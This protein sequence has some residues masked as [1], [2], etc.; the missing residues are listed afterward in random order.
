MNKFMKTSLLASATALAF[1]AG[2][3]IV[4]EDSFDAAGYT[5]GTGLKNLK[6]GASTGFAAGTAW[7]DSSSS[8]VFY[9]ND[10]LSLPDDFKASSSGNAIGVGKFS[11]TATGSREI[12]RPINADVIGL[13]GTYYLRFACSI[14]ES[15]E[16]YLNFKGF[17]LLGL[18]PDEHKKSDAISYPAS[19]GLQFGF[20]KTSA[21]D[22]KTALVVLKEGGSNAN[23]DPLK[24]VDPVVPGKTYIVVAKIVLDGEGG[25]EV[26]AMAG[27]TDDLSFRTKSLPETPFAVSVNAS[28]PLRYLVLSGTF[29][30]GYSDGRWASF[31]ELAI[32]E[33]LADVFGF[34]ALTIP[35]LG[36]ATSSNVGQE[37]FSASGELAQ[38]GDSSPEVFF[39]ISADGG[40]TFTSTSLGVFNAAGPISHQ[41]TGLSAGT[42]Y[43]WRFRAVGASGSDANEWQSVT[44][45][46]APALGAPSAEVAGSSAT[47]SV[48]LVTPG[49]SGTVDST[50]EL[51]F[52]ADGQPLA[53]EATLGTASFPT[54]FSATV[55]NLTLGETYCYAFRATVPYNS[56]SIET[57]SATNSFSISA[58]VVWTG[59]AGT[60]WGEAGNWNPQIAPVASVS[61][62]FRTVGGAVTSTANGEAAAIHV[63]TAGS[64][65][66]F[67][68]G[69]NSLTAGSFKVGSETSQS[70]AA[71]GPGGYDF[72][73]VSIG[74]GSDVGG[75][76]DGSAENHLEVGA[77]A[78]LR[79]D[80]MTVGF[81]LELASASNTV[82]FAAGSQSTIDGAL[83]IRAA[84][85]SGVEVENGAALTVGSLSLESTG[86]S[87]IVD[88][89]AFTNSGDTVVMS[90]NRLGTVSD[91]TVLELK[92]G[93]RGK[94]KSDVYVNTGR[95]SGN[96]IVHGELRILSGAVADLTGKILFID[97][98]TSRGPNS[99][100][101][102]SVRVIVSN[103]TLNA[104]AVIVCND[105]RHHDDLLL[106]HEDEGES[107]SITA[108]G[109]FRV[110][111]ASWGRSDNCNHDNRLRVESGEVAIRGTLFLGDSGAYYATHKDNRVEI[112][113]SNPRISAK[114]MEVLGASY[115]AFEIPSGGYAGVPLTVTLAADFGIV[116]TGQD[117]ESWTPANEIRVDASQ[118]V[119]TQV[120]LRAGTIS[121]L[122]K[123]RVK[124]VAPAG[125]KSSVVLTETELS[126]K[127]SASSTIMVFR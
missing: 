126:I 45:V 3:A 75:V 86:V 2:A 4:V 58:D 114:S 74:Y 53:L 42:T 48:S 51:W 88:G 65:T 111:S 17:E 49:L 84:R 13:S 57:W 72:G 90:K 50:V 24:L 89:G 9:V 118:F 101:G 83:S 56:G 82:T 29:M 31:D 85:G 110:A 112:A 121:G 15:A 87:M 59:N 47:L 76:V 38:T 109:N 119:G 123:S 7:G 125:L 28:K 81:P 36:P 95:N 78:T 104:N 66:S 80:A 105:D 5:V 93:A 108:S 16:H 127:V 69:A 34:E 27:A 26:Y 107:A 62:Y 96:S 113:G 92:N 14:T 106:V 122:D 102:E 6:P 44:L 20:Y 60:S 12:S 40:E 18:L 22:N 52:A 55:D 97:D 23:V 54:N 98:W 67:D 79:A 11:G 103:A 71:L 35:V 8:G 115:I 70:R 100:V 21:G 68:F 46:G 64:G 77:T 39:D 117:A 73:D 10:G 1:H 30:T 116:P 63:N 25:A 32:G 37:S 41:A 124:V 61:T 120:L 94:F 43:D 33:S 19:N 91:P 99:D